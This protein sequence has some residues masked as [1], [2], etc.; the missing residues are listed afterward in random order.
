MHSPDAKWDSHLIGDVVCIV[1]MGGVVSALDCIENII[2]DLRNSGDLLGI[3]R[4]LCRDS[5]GMWHEVLLSDSQEFLGFAA[6]RTNSLC[7]AL[8]L[9]GIDTLPI[10]T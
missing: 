2:G 5:D 3:R 10:R 7:T 9:V 1:D 4:C 6:A 8:M